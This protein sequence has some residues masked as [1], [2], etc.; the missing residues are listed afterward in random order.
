MARIHPLA[1]TEGLTIEEV[2][3]EVRVYG[4][5]SDVGC[6]LNETAAIVWRS[7]DGKRTLKDL[8]AVVSEQLGTPADEDMVLMAWTGS[9][10]HGLLL[11]GYEHEAA[12]LSDS[13]AADSSTARASPAPLRSPRRWSTP[14]PRRRSRSV[15]LHVSVRSASEAQHQDPPRP[16][17]APGS[18]G[19]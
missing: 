3:D 1:R 10:L 7:C 9:R 6:V 18:A 16:A 14:P 11:S 8:V 19:R 15:T 2:E 13:A 17:I 12:A 5:T 4:E